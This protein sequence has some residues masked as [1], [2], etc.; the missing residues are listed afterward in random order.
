VKTVAEAAETCIICESLSYSGVTFSGHRI[1]EQ[2]LYRI[3]VA[4]PTS[5]EYVVIVEKIGQMWRDLGI[6][7]DCHCDEEEQ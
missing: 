1:C 5:F 2:C 6:L 4:D 7:N 3:E